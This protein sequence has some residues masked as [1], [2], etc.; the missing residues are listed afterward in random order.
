MENSIIAD[1]INFSNPF[2]F[3]D[4][5]S[6]KG[7]LSFD[8][9]FRDSLFIYENF[10]NNFLHD[11]VFISNSYTRIFKEYKNFFLQKLKD[12]EKSSISKMMELNDLK[13]LREFN[14]LDENIKYFFMSK[15]GIFGNERIVIEKKEDIYEVLFSAKSNS[16]KN[17]LEKKFYKVALEIFNTK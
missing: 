16:A 10:K 1:K 9:N 6:K 11:S 17:R 14:D 5:N 3:E 4:K 13:D 15:T 8:L 2:S 7:Y 12:K